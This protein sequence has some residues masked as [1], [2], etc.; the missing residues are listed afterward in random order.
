MFIK[1]TL[2]VALIGL[3]AF[4]LA[5][6]AYAYAASNTVPDGKAGDGSGTITGY[7]VTNVVYTQ[8]SGNP[9]NITA[10]AFDLDA[11]ATSVKVRLITAGALQACTN[12]SGT[13]WTCAISGVTV[14][15]A[16]TLEV[17]ASQ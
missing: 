15:A 4:S 7:N 16:D 17:V 12:P 3:L 14:T 10:V 11:A 1:R 2:K 13:H 5:T 9:V 8:D 6:V